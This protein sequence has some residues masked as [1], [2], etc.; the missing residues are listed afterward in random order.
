MLMGQLCHYKQK[1][2]YAT[3]GT[4]YSPLMNWAVPHFSHVTNP[5]RVY[6]IGL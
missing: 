4:L 5:A 6:K 2:L 1:P 3:E